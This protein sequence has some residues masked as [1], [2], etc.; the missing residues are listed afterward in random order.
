MAAARIHESF[1]RHVDGVLS[2][3]VDKCVFT[4]VNKS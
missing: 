2:T 4:K 3:W 1:P